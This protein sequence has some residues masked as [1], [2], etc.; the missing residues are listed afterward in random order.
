MPLYVCV[1][2]CVRACACVRVCVC[3]CVCAC[4]CA[5]VCYAFNLLL[6]DWLFTTP[7]VWPVLSYVVLCT[8]GVQYISSMAMPIPPYMF[9]A[10]HTIGAFTH[11]I[12]IMSTEWEGNQFSPVQ[13]LH[14]EF[15]Q[16]QLYIILCVSLH[17]PVECNNTA[18]GIF[19]S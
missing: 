6:F 8:D 9:N 11:G 13:F 4:V 5:C 16:R 3:V 14:W 12:Q 1:R 19:Q 2:A 18:L 17:C 10:H 7:T 15:G